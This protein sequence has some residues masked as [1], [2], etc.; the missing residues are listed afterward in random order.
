M[1]NNRTKNFYKATISEYIINLLFNINGS[2]TKTSA[3][4][5]NIHGCLINTY[6]RLTNISENE[7]YFSKNTSDLGVNK[8]NSN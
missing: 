6:A 2:F 5:I 8:I 1:G 7:T 3:R 4:V